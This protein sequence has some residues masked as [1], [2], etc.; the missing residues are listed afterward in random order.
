MA[1]AN[2]GNKAQTKVSERIFKA[3]RA[4][5]YPY[6]APLLSWLEGGQESH[7][8]GR[9]E[10]AAAGRIVC[11]SKLTKVDKRALWKAIENARRGCEVVDRFRPGSRSTQCL[12]ELNSIRTMVDVLVLRLSKDNDATDLIAENA[13][14]MV[15]SIHKL[16]ARVDWFCEIFEAI[17]RKRYP[18]GGASK[19]RYS[20]LI[21]SREV[22]LA[23]IELPCV[24]EELT[25]SVLLPGQQPTI[26]MVEFIQAVMS[27]IG[28]KYELSS[29]TTAIRKF[30]QD[31][32]QRRLRRQRGQKS[33]LS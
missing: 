24:Y 33:A 5:M 22:W 16:K 15:W 3:A 26:E 1:S 6:E 30:K 11:K 2:A 13:A 23:G 29:I 7:P 17:N 20:E 31:R 9:E 21:P 32:R 18:K 19:D 28:I 8:I 4:E 27:E 10:L 25:Q 14:E 12:K